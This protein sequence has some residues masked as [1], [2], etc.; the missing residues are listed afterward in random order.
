MLLFMEKLVDISAV[1]VVNIGL[2]I[3]TLIIIGIPKDVVDLIKK[4]VEWENYKQKS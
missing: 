4:L 3:K 2:L 1:D